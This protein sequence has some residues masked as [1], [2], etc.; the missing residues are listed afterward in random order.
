MIKI[1]DR[2]HQIRLQRK[3]ECFPIVNRGRLWYDRL[4]EEQMSELGEWYQA[5][6]DAPQTGAIPEKLS[7]LNDKT[8]EDEEIW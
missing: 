4:T 2:R 7:W 8:M 6:L 5:W 3:F 1:K